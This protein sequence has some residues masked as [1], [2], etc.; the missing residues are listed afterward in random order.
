MRRLIEF[1][2]GVLT[3][4]TFVALFATIIMYSVVI[5][6]PETQIAIQTAIVSVRGCD[7]I[8]LIQDD[9]LIEAFPA[10]DQPKSCKVMNEQTDRK[11]AG[12]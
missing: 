11:K 3:G 10:P 2:L 1:S 7:I 5:Q 6:K 8:Q 4:A 9:K 12:K